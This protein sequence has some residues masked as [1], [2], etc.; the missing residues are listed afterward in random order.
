[1][2]ITDWGWEKSPGYTGLSRFPST[3]NFELK[4]SPDAELGRDAVFVS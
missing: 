1:M 4:T 2:P 3:A